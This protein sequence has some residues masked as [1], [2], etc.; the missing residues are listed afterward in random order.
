MCQEEGRIMNEVAIQDI[1]DAMTE[2][3][4]IVNEEG[5]ILFVNKEWTAFSR[6]NQGKAKWTDVG[7]DYFESVW[8]AAE[9]GDTY[10]AKAAQGIEEILLGESTTFELEYPC[11]S[12]KEERWFI[13]NIREIGANSPRTFL[14]T[15]KNVSRLVLR[16]KKI[17]DAQHME[18]IGQLTGGISHDFNNLLS[19]IM[20]NLELAQEM[21]ADKNDISSYID[22][23]LIA[24]HRGASLIQRILSFTR[25][26]A[27]FPEDIQVNSFILETVRLI[28]RTLGEDIRIVTKFEE[29][30]LQL[31]TDTAMLG[32]SILNIA[33]NARHAMPEGG[34]LTIRTARVE[35]HGQ[36]FM[37]GDTKAY[38][39]YA[40]IAI[41]DTGSGIAEEH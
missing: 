12:E 37:P 32:N 30:A 34:T 31:H 38:G 18:L 33:I 25:Q 6:Q 28:T 3:A 10:A 39:P 23:S 17:Q 14:F 2:H 20:G 9:T 27:V 35:L 26:Q 16:E 1:L 15:H 13:C 22:N 19:V 5:R 21:P 40:L 7:A 36:T 24:V 29:D 11:N 8:N 41:S 4:A